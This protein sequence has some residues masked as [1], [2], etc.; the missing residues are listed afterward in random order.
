MP[1]KNTSKTILLVEDEAP[2]A[3]NEAQ[4][5]GK[6]GFEV[7]TAYNGKK[8]ID[9][10]NANSIDLILMDIDLGPGKMD[11]T[12]AAQVILKE[13]DLPIV[14]LTSHAEK[15]MVDKV[16]SITNYGYILKNSGEFVIIESI[17]MAFELFESHKQVKEARD[18][19]F[20]V[21]ELTEE[22]INRIDKNGRWIFLNSKAKKF[23][24]LSGID[25]SEKKYIDFVHPDDKEK[26]ISAG[27]Q[28]YA[29]KKPVSGLINRQWTPEGWRT[30]EWNSSPIIDDKGE[31]IGFQATGRDITEEKQI[32]KR[33]STISE[34][35]TDYVYTFV[36]ETDGSI[37]L[38]WSSPNFTE[39]AKNVNQQDIQDFINNPPIHP[40]DIPVFEKRSQKL[41]SNKED[42]SEYRIVTDSGETIWVRDYGKPI[43]DDVE[44]RVTQIIGAIQDITELK[45]VQEHY[46]LITETTSDVVFQV[47]LHGYV[48]YCTPSARNLLGFTPDEVIG[49]NFVRFFPE[50]WL[51]FAKQKFE[52]VIETGKAMTLEVVI[53][54]K[55]G[56]QVPVEVLLEPITEDRQVGSI[57]GNVRDISDRK[58]MEEKL[59]KSEGK[60]KSLYE[61]S[62]LPYQALDENGFFLEVNPAWLETMGGYKR[63]E[64]LGKAFAEFLH[65]DS[66]EDFKRN[67][68]EFKRMGIAKKNIYTMRKRNGE[69]IDVSFQ[70]RIAYSQEGTFERTHCV[71]EDIT[72]RKRREEERKLNEAR[73]EAL[74]HLQEM[75]QTDKEKLALFALE[76]SERLTKSRIGFIN[77][78]SDDEK[79]VTHAVYT[80]NTMNQC[81]LPEDVSAFTISSCGLWSE[82]YRQRE[83]IIVNDYSAEHAAKAGFPEGHPILKRFVSI[84]IFKENKIVAVAALGNKEAE[85]NEGDVRQFR[86]FMEGMYQIV[87][88]KQGV[89]RLQRLIEDKDFLLK[90][91]NHRVKNN[92]Y[93]ISSLISLKDSSLGEEVDLSDIS[94][95]IDAIR[96]VHD[97]L[98]QGEEITHINLREYVQELLST[99]FSFSSRQVEI[100]NNMK[101]VSIGTRTAIPIG[102]I[103][104]EIATNAIKHGFTEEETRFTVD[105]QEDTSK[106]QYI[107]TLSNTGRPFHKD[108]NVDNPATVGLQLISALV[109]QIDGT[110][111]L[112]KEPYPVFTIRF[113]E[114][115]L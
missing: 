44:K 98:Y 37:K 94:R 115:S 13:Y 89:E 55:S 19:Y 101:D 22:I 15:E 1:E 52:Q 40:D 71:F 76:E 75:A 28:M 30:V 82:A 46:K 41:F 104:N 38:E 100:E 91:L 66:I 49:S 103:V 34:I 48:T 113:P 69:Y 81:T 27:E 9:K 68:E 96:I 45:E 53:T 78:L 47:D 31:A 102:L 35:T 10:V 97:E 7:I 73:L 54:D 70:G 51:S 8:A 72:E 80:Q 92:L 93:M 112:Q 87:L 64:I 39:G 85:Y 4:M 57:R 77:F 21:V 33:L 60:Y 90:E 114:V 14:F 109:E 88:R 32:E 24:G 56:R 95:Q 29:T 23:W 26:T 86:L 20:S 107:L 18:E 50:T 36:V 2:I 59:R 65:P 61:N 106:N 42:I 83:A 84:P 67:F 6:H 108:V 16:K 110:F 17:N 5:L 11:G 58:K 25:L 43:W 3:M 99:V 74:L 12:E 62:P 79:Y 105:L 63:E 111:E